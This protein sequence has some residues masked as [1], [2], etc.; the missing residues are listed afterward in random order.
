MNQDTIAIEITNQPKDRPAENLG[1][2][3]YFT[4]HMFITEYSELLGWHAPR[5]VPYQS[6][7]LD[8]GA[9]VLHYGQAIFEGMKVFRGVDGKVRLFRPEMNHRRMVASAER[10][11]MKFVDLD[12]FIESILRL[13]RTDIDWV[14]SKN[15]TAL[16]LRPTLIGSEAFLGVRP[17]EAF[18]YYVIASP[19]G[20]YYGEN[21]ETVKIWV[22]REYSRAAPGGIG[23]TKAGGNYAASLKAATEAKKRGF[24]QVLWLDSSE[25]HY[26][27][28]VGTMNVFFVIGDEV[29]TP[30][31]GG[32]ILPGVTR[33]SV[34]ELLRA[35]GTKITERQ[36]SLDEI[37]EAHKRGDLKEA[38]G[39]GTAASISPIGALGF[40]TNSEL[41][42]INN[43]KVGEISKELYETLTDIQ[44]GRRA[45]EFGW[46][47]EIPLTGR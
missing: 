39:S 16:Y 11:C 9:A 28:E 31:L 27:E 30:P 47:M 23:M 2:G 17:A 13:V 5:I 19:V 12:I 21:I 41:M 29:V 44:Y 14:P 40:G 10:L 8:P 15:G 4:D 43:G 26:V 22:E 34:I 46:T 25:K 33:D 32:T 1:F 20:G 36:I 35:R 24:A 18:I 3:K 38:F 42:T 6:L 37:I 45:D 7:R